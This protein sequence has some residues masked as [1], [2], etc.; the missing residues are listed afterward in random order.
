METVTVMVTVLVPSEMDMVVVPLFEA[1]TP[2]DVMVNAPVGP[3]EGLIV[4]ID[5]SALDAVK[6]P[7]NPDSETVTVVLIPMPPN[8]TVDGATV[9]LPVVTLPETTAAPF[10]PVV[11]ACVEVTTG[12]A[13]AVLPPD[14]AVG[15]DTTGDDPPPPPPPPHEASTAA[16]E[17]IAAKPISR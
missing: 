4:A 13:V 7:V 17:T 15:S 1:P 9:S 6:V 12:A 10:P 16:K 8:A 5:E 14:A 11:G 2:V 3:E